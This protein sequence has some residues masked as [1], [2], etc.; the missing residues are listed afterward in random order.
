MDEGDRLDAVGV[1]QHVDADQD[2]DLAAVEL[3]LAHAAE[4]GKERASLDALGQ[5]LD[6]LRAERRR[7][8]GDHR[9]PQHRR[10]MIGGGAH[11]GLELVRILQK[12]LRPFREQAAC[13]R[14]LERPRGAVD[15]GD[16][17]RF[18]EIRQRLR[19]GRLADPELTRRLG[20]PARH[21]DGVEDLQ[22]PEV[23]R[24]FLGH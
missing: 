19:D 11:D 23:E 12:R 4:I 14:R 10:R 15:E 13:G 7:E 21:H 1:L 9:D 5:L 2:I 24:K 6:E 22:L 3:L 18:L 16:A 20:E 17:H 8:R